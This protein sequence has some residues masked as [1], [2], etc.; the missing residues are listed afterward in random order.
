MS[1]SGNFVGRKRSM[2]TY[3]LYRL[4][5]RAASK[6][7]KHVARGEARR[8]SASLGVAPGTVATRVVGRA[9]VV[10]YSVNATEAETTR[11]RRLP[12]SASTTLTASVTLLA[13][14]ILNSCSYPGRHEGSCNSPTHAQ[15]YVLPPHPGFVLHLRGDLFHHQTV[16]PH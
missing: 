6:R 12:N 11:R 10:P 5:A 15:G 16:F 14:P 13:R 1:S 8:A 7:R 2:S 4:R 9:S 3:F